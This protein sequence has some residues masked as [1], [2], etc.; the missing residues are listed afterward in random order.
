MG[1][2]QVFS[3]KDGAAWRRYLDLI[4]EKEMVHFPLYTRAYECY[5][6]GVGEC[7]VYENDG[8]VL[9]PYLRRSIANSDRLTDISTPYGYGG[10]IHVCGSAQS[11]PQLFKGFRKAFEEYARATNTVSEFVRFHP[12]LANHEHLHGLMDEIQFQCGNALIDLSVGPEAM[13]SQYRVSYQQCIR[14]AKSAELS[15]TPL[16]SPDF[17][18]PF[19]ELY[20]ASMSRKYQKGYLL[21][22]REF[23]V[24]LSNELGDTLKCFAV[25]QGEDIL[26][27]ALFLHSRT[28][29]DYFLAAAKPEA[30]PLRPNHILLHEVA[31]WAMEN[32]IARFHLGGGHPS[33]QFFKRGFANAN[34]DY[35]IGKHVFDQ[36]A[37]TRLS[38]D[39]WQ[40][41]GKRWPPEEPS[42]FPGYRVDFDNA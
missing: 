18:D 13:F 30:L 15:V 31:L 7:F 38:N 26:A 29:L 22:R 11:R 14:K 8:I 41:H 34:C 19:F 21:F 27:V 17:I 12:L 35:Y 23:L 25:K 9:Y 5:G 36:D 2:Y 39:H 20:S 40:R 10:A 24:H 3:T 33:L 32:K 16:E 1:T 42:H 37:Y 6:D 4:P 28:Y